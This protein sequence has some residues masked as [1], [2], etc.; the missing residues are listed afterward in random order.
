MRFDR[1]RIENFRPHADVDLAL[2][3]GVT[4][5]HGVNGSGKSSLLEAC[6]FALYGA[7]ALEGTLED[8][9][10]NGEEETTVDLAFTHG[11]RDYRIERRVK[12]R[13]DR[14]TTTE[15]VLQTPDGSVEGARDV[16]RRVT[17]LLRMDEDAFVNCA[18][19]R[20]GEVNELIHASPAQRQDVIDDLLQLGKLETYRER[21]GEARL[22]VE[23]V[24][25]E[26]RGQLD[27]LDEQIADKE[28]R[29]LHARLNDLE[30][31]LK[32]VEADVERLEG[33][34]AEA[35][36]T[37]AEAQSLLEEHRER[38]EELVELRESVSDLQATI[39]ETERER[40]AL[41]EEIREGRDRV[42]S[43]D[44][45]RNELLAGTELPA[46]AD[47]E[48][49]AER[50]DSLEADREEVAESLADLRAERRERAAEVQ[51]LRER[52][53]DLDARTADEREEADDLAETVAEREDAL[54]ERRE[55]LA[56]L[57]TEIERERARFEDAP[58]E[59]GEAEAHREDLDAEREALEAEA[60]E[61]Q[62]EVE[63]LR[64]AVETGEALEAA[65]KCPECGQPVEGSPHVDSLAE[66]REALAEAED[67]LA[68]VREELADVDER[69][70]RAEE[71]VAAEQ[72]VER[73]TERRRN[74]AALVSEREADLADRRERVAALRES[75]DDLEREAEDVRAEADEAAADVEALA[76]RIDDRESELADLDD[77]VDHLREVQSLSDERGEVADRLATL[78]ERR[79]SKAELN[80]ERRDRLAEL[81]E[82]RDDI[83]QAHDE[84]A[85]EEARAEK[86]RAEAYLEEVE[87]RL[88]T[89]EAERTRLQS[90]VGAVENQLAELDEL[91]DRRD[92]L[93]ERLAAIETLHDE[94]ERLEHT[95]GD[96]RAELRQRNVDHLER[97]L[98]EVF[99]L[100]YGND[101]YAHIELSGE[102]ELTVYQKDGETLDP[103]Q[104]SGGERAL[105]NL[106]LRTAIYRLLAEGIEGSAPM[107]PL[108]LD[109]PTVFLDAGHVSRLVDLVESM[110][111]RGVEQIV[112]VSHDEELVGAADDLVTVRK[113]PT[114]NR[115][116][117]QRREQALPVD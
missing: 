15:C 53:E 43:L 66:D 20:Q 70:E 8:V 28:D 108:I 74:V 42:Q 72:A 71:L 91:R 79:E 59:F 89:L 54:E 102:Y 77:H 90:E 25:G 64:D 52:A 105:F 23:D 9:I 18:Y 3:R 16:R 67:E 65:G 92:A 73:L 51:R 109:E 113:D 116:S 40:E 11:G 78:R 88:A 94:T 111:E 10:T 100:V 7:H 32:E 115:S 76:E 21:A 75:A 107:P 98:N 4:V 62:V 31:E 69:V 6:F 83:E 24:L 17:E 56:E 114:T 14:A 22:G 38:R 13:G 112:V 26:V 63:R 30:S 5:I 48:A 96:L 103:E 93:A 46:N 80:A 106:S 95:Y 104:L 1:I 34:R 19:V 84:A 110:R 50:L 68:T 60:A 45:Q 55:E 86:E 87:S 85:V 99:D 39:T 61:L 97:L 82:R 117:V 58:V 2:D 44:E 101:S 37:L 47:E 41:Q 57:D 12:L 49:V 27:G 35:E 36:E 29:D 33:N 81:R